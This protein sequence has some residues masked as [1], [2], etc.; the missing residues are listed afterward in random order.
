M[1]V[2][3]PGVT[4]QS[5]GQL[6]EQ[7]ANNLEAAFPQ[8]VA[9]HASTVYSTALRVSR[10]P[11]DADDLASETLVRA[12]RALQRYPPERVRE[13]ALRPWLVT[14]VLNLWRNQ[15]RDAS[16]R[17]RTVPFGPIHPATE[18]ADGPEQT[19]LAHRDSGDVGQ[20]LAGLPEAQRIPIV[21]RHVVGLSYAEIATVLEC[22]AGTA[23]SQVSR[24]LAALRAQLH[25]VEEAL[26]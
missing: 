4:G 25:Q 20:L 19:A 23:K 16:R 2:F 11:A 13:L 7:A 5:D 3:Y 8:I 10:Q 6:T 14:I 15:L 12:Y 9:A 26:P 18:P 17:P 22:P 21:L 1:T 24:G